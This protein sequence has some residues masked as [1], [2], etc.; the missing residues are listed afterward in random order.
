MNDNSRAGQ[1][2][3]ERMT[4]QDTQP[5]P[6]IQHKQAPSAGWPWRFLLLLG[7]LGTG[8]VLAGQFRQG[9]PES[10]RVSWRTSYDQAVQEAGETG[11]PLLV[12]FGAD[13]CGPCEQMKARVF[14][15]KTVADTIEARFVPLRVDLTENGGPNDSLARRFGVTGIPALFVLD[16]RGNPISRSAGYMGKKDLL[17]WMEGVRTDPSTAT[18]EG[19]LSDGQTYAGSNRIE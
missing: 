19:T 16:P 8:I 13:W 18:A 14:S 10:D 17:G 12:V 2:D 7:V 5:G 11:R 6:D 4:P 9:D 3:H 15:D 1:T